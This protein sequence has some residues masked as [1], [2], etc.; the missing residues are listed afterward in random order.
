MADPLIAIVGSV[1]PARTAEIKLKHAA[2]GEKAAEAIGAALARQRCRIV[3]YSDLA[4]SVELRVVKGYV[5]ECNGNPA[6]KDFA[7]LPDRIEVRY[8]ASDPRPHF[9]EEK[10]NPE[11]FFS[12]RPNKNPSWASAFYRSLNEVDGLVLLGGA[13]TT[14]VAGTVAISHRKPV[15]PLHAYGGAAETLWEEL[16]PEPG[17][18]EQADIDRMATQSWSPQA[19]DTLVK[20]LL[21]QSQRLEKK[22][23]DI[24][25][26]K[27]NKWAARQVYVAVPLLVASLA[28]VPFTWDNPDLPRSSLL[29][30]LLM[31][32]L[33]GGI[34]G[35]TARTAFEAVGGNLPAEPPNLGRTCGLG[36]IAGAVAGALFIVAQLV[37][38]S[39]EIG[40]T[41]WSKQAG[42]L[43]PFAVLIGFIAGLTL[44]AVFRR[45]AGMSVVTDEM[46]KILSERGGARARGE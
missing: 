6:L 14:Y 5:A 39:P 19:A 32:P 3:A 20:S 27:R 36:A 16:S 17:V 35:A 22:R 46:L 15:A 1:Q 18:L 38:M 25:A 45:L 24:D 21:T 44:D 28:A 34:S 29:S 31:G 26:S 42:R 9:A 13:H 2:E 43:V 10:T 33:L 7:K 23:K 40:P 41:I 37:S 8:A 12:F 4:L 30:I 11:P